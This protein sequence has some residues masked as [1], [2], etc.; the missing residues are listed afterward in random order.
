LISDQPDR[1]RLGAALEI[2]EMN[3]TFSALGSYLQQTR[4]TPWV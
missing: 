1:D 2:V 3:E 4:F